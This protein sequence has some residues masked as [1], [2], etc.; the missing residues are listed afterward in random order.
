MATVALI[1]VKGNL[2][3]KIFPELVASDYV[4]K[5]H[6]L[7]RKKRD[8]GGGKVVDFQVDYHD[9]DSLEK[10]LKGVDA[11][12]NTMGTEGDFQVAKKNLVDA[13]AKAGVR[14]YFPR[15]ADKS[16]CANL[17]SEWGIDPQVDTWAVRH[18]IWDGKKADD[19]YAIQ[20]GLKV[21]PV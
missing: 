14:I 16:S 4:Q 20:K 13:A 21:I 17:F 2:G 6:V 9:P 1:G 5:I 8:S 12:I 18:K 7:S 11:I 15:Y 10:A 3:Y 19:A